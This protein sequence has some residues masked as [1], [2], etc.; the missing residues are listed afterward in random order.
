MTTDDLTEWILQHM[1][2]FCFLKELTCICLLQ[3][4]PS[5]HTALYSGPVVAC[6]QLVEKGLS[7]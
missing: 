7:C 6:A 3:T 2:K 4:Q 5:L 1:A